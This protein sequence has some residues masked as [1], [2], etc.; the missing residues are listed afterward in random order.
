MVDLQLELAFAVRDRDGR[1]L[2][3]EELHIQGELLMQA[4][5]EL[6]RINDDVKDAATSSDSEAGRVTVELYVTAGSDADAV[7]CA[8]NICRTAIHAIGGSTPTWPAD[9]SAEARADFTPQNVQFD[10]V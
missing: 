6:E 9:S 5:L 8:M 3:P 1:M 4:L 10:Y 2:P 7:A